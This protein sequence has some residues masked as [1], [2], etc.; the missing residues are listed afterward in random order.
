MFWSNIYWY[1]WSIYESQC[2]LSNEIT[3]LFKSLTSKFYETSKY[4]LR[5]ICTTDKYTSFV[6][7][8]QYSVSSRS[9][10][11]TWRI[12]INSNFRLEFRWKTIFNFLIYYYLWFSFLKRSRIVNFKIM[13]R[14][15]APPKKVKKFFVL[16]WPKLTRSWN[17]DITGPKLR[18]K[19]PRELYLI[20]SD[21][22]KLKDIPHLSSQKKFTNYICIRK[23][24][25]Q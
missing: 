4:N 6:F 22:G 20:M 23:A 7:F 11:W 18:L 16:K 10:S 15:L 12:S 1:Y 2:V 24:L 19:N 21:L 17:M 25:G 3:R 5:Y 9:N 8:I 13:S 14:Y